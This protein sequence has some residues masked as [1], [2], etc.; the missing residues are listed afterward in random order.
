MC[1]G[2]IIFIASVNNILLFQ[3]TSAK[4]ENK[5]LLKTAVQKLKIFALRLE[6]LKN[7]NIPLLAKPDPS[8]QQS[9]PTVKNGIGL[10]Q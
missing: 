10:F 9:C 7:K 3:Q 4:K 2:I 8:S 5:L 6:T 1:R